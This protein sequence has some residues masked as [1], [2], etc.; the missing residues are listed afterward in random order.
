MEEAAAD[1]VE[2]A[3]ELELKGGKGGFEELPHHLCVFVVGG[4][5]S[6]SGGLSMIKETLP[7]AALEGLD[8]LI[9]TALSWILILCIFANKDPPTIHGFLLVS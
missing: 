9:L 3:R 4:W 7:N 5:K 1:V 6:V 8:P 2:K